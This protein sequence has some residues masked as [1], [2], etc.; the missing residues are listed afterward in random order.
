[1]SRVHRVS[2]TL[3]GLLALGLAACTATDPI[4]RT[5]LWRPNGS[6]EQNLRLMVVDQRDLLK[7][8]GETGSDGAEASA[9]IE[10]LRAGKLKD[11][12]VETTQTAVGGGQ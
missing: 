6:N 8:R 4:S 5:G 12:R 7:G 3:L 2:L 9:A 1:M 10:R 11:I